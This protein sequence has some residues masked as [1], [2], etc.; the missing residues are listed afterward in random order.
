MNKS[1]DRINKL[2]AKKDEH[3]PPIAVLAAFTCFAIAIALAIY[4]DTNTSLSDGSIAVIF[5]PIFLVGL[6]FMMAIKVAS[7]WEKAVILRF[8]RYHKLARPGLFWIIPIV[9]SIS[10]WIDQ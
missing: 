5:T 2:F 9:D 1:T 4:L 7:Q 8:G 6:Y 10:N 3:I